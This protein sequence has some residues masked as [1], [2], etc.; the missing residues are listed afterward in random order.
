VLRIA[1]GGLLGAVIWLSAAPAYA[2]HVS[3]ADH[4]N[5]G[6]TEFTLTSPGCPIFMGCGSDRVS[7][8]YKGVRT[9]VSTHDFEDNTFPGNTDYVDYLWS[10]QR[11]GKHNWHAVVRNASGDATD[12]KRGT[13]V[14]PACGPRRDRRVSRGK[15]ETTVEEFWQSETV[16]KVHCTATSQ[17]SNAGLAARWSC[18][19]RH[20]NANRKCD[21]RYQLRFWKRS[22][23]GGAFIKRG[24][25]SERHRLGCQS[26]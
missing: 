21:E 3:V 12:D 5:P 25:H 14:V 26:V 15:A 8:Y 19:L 9:L 24:F 4:P 6:Y 22:M 17:V 13:I 20:A 18:T 2:A 11:P 7:I 23:F 1:V 16:T 10:C